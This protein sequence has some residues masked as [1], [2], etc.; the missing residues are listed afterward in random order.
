MIK[1]K[2]FH[3]SS[4]PCV[5]SARQCECAMASQCLVWLALLCC[6]SYV[7]AEDPE[8]NYDAVSLRM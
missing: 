1:D 5:L 7:F 4:D 3:K 6:C 2:S 8:V